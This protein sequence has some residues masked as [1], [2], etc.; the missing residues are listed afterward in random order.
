VAEAAAEVL[1][2]ED[3]RAAAEADLD[4]ALRVIQGD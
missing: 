4:V 1:R 2:A 3:P